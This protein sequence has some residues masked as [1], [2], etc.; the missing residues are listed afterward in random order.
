M[1]VKYTSANG[2]LEINISAD[3]SKGIFDKIAEF[4][5][6]FESDTC[7]KCGGTDI[8]YVVREVDGDKYYELRC[9][10]KACNAK[11]AYGQSKDQLTIYPKRTEQEKDA[12]GKPI[13]EK[14]WLN[15]GGWLRWNKAT[16]TAE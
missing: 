5:E 7:G 9:N 10:N 4:Q 1:D 11:L 2:R 6:V 3:G 12:K 13:G 15:D 14:K 8:K 16:Q